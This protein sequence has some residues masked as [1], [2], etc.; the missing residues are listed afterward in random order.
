MSKKK[1]YRKVGKRGQKVE[2]K[3]QNLVKEAQ[4]MVG[5]FN[6][7]EYLAAGIPDDL[8]P[9]PY[10]DSIQEKLDNNVPINFSENGIFHTAI[11]MQTIAYRAS[12]NEKVIS[13]DAS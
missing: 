12:E 7:D 13:N 1:V 6:A 11:P 5:D 2:Q 9:N 3:A 10:F 8:P 4:S